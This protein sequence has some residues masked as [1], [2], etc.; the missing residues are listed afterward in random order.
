MNKENPKRNNKT[1]LRR[2]SWER[3]EHKDE[4]ESLV[5]ETVLEWYEAKHRKASDKE[6]E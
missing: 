6:L 4:K 3:K 5:E 2:F 1:R